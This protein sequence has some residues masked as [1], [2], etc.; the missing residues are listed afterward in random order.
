MRSFIFIASLTVAG[1]VA[2]QT[3]QPPQPPQQQMMPYVAIHDPV[4]VSP[5]QATYAL[6]D[7]LVIGVAKA[8]IA[9]AYLALDL[10]QH[11][12]VDD[13]MPDG[14]IEVTWCGTCG[15]PARSFAPS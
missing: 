6:D 4:F 15:T 12:S 7:D 11:G 1:S 10:T 5:S 3:V 14:P 2:A 8:T 13:R 9:K